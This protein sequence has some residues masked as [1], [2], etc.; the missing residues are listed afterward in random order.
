MFANRTPVAQTMRISVYGMGYVGTVTAACLARL[1]HQVWGV[2]VNESKVDSINAGFS[3]VTEPRLAELVSTVVAQGRLRATA[4]SEQAVNESEASLIC[5]G[6]PGHPDGSI[7]LSYIIRVCEQI[8]DAMRTKQDRHTVVVRSTVLPGT[9]EN[10]LAPTLEARSG[11]RIGRDFVVC[12]N[13]EFLREGSSI[14]DFLAPPFTLIGADNPNDAELL[15][16]L[17]AAID[18]PQIVVAIKTAEMIK[19]ACN[20]FHALKV[21][22]ANEIGNLCSTAGIDAGEV[23]EVFCR[24]TRLNLSPYYLKPGFAF[25]G[26]CLPKDLRALTQRARELD[27]D[28]PLLSAI[29]ESNRR[30]IDRAVAQVLQTGRKR[31]GILGL[32]FKS[33]TDDLRESALVTLIC[34]L[35]DHG[36]EV[37]VY[38]PDVS[39]GQLVGVNKAYIERTI[40]ALESMMCESTA[41]IVAT[42][43]VVVVGKA[44]D[45]FQGI[46]SGMRDDQVLIDLAASVDRCGARSD[47]LLT[48]S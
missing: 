47:V 11:T 19:Y 25:G 16:Q 1:G 5:V 33:G 34:R 38:D 3:P 2:D 24:D 23:M 8:G 36:V 39:L 15:R 41:E 27:V 7:D 6:T 48:V 32:S 17:Y 35:L 30:Q 43:D 40:P 10:V 22:F 46:E 18:A 13:P 31:V 45:C 37:R 44:S 21:G 14:Q 42:T 20:A 4:D 12:S 9:I 28:V 26:S 29:D